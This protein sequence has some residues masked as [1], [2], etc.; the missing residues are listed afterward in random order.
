MLKSLR[1]YKT[2]RINKEKNTLENYFQGNIE[3][4]GK[5][6]VVIDI[7]LS[8]EEQKKIYKIVWPKVKAALQQNIDELPK[9]LEIA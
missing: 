1:I 9:E 5:S 4:E 2:C 7:D 6:E 3:V 8:E